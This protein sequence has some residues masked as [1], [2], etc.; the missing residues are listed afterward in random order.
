MARLADGDLAL[1][2]LL[3]RDLDEVPAAL[4]AERRDRNADEL[5]VD[6]RVQP[7]IALTNRLLDGLRF[8]EAK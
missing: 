1:L 6:L 5:S 8:T 7:E 3:L 4:L 2:A